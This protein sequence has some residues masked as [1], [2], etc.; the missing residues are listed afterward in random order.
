MVRYITAGV[1]VGTC[2]QYISYHRKKRSLDRGNIEVM[3]CGPK[4]L[5][6]VKWLELKRAVFNGH[7]N[8][9]FLKTS[10]VLIKGQH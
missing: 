6:Q 3:T 7:S 4:Y 5:G 2:P 1:S 8:D 10:H 9:N